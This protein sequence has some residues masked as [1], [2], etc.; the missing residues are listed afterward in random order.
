MAI[1]VMVVIDEI[2]GTVEFKPIFLKKELTERA[3]K[4][5]T[6]AVQSLAVAF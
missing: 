2:T 3:V 1:S 5:T 6:I 4:S